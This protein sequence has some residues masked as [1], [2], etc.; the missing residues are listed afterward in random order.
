MEGMAN[1]RLL[2]IL[3]RKEIINPMQ[4]GFSKNRSSSNVLVRLETE[5][6]NAFA[7]RKPLIAV[8]FDIK[9][10]YD[11]TWRRGILKHCVLMILK[12][13]SVILLSNF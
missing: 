3:E 7:M 10:A 8:F 6:R 13:E 9:N 2:H 11:T 12:V 4:Y 5:I 1:T